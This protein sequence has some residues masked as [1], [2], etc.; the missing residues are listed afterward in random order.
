M[1]CQSSRFCGKARPWGLTRHRATIRHIL[2]PYHLPRT[3]TRYQ[4]TRGNH[5]GQP[6]WRYPKLF[7][8]QASDH[9]ELS[10]TPH[11]LAA[12]QEMRRRASERNHLAAA[13]RQ[14]LATCHFL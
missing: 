10:R 3:R 1:E 13:V 12:P 5:P 11:M 14:S 7:T 9:L 6:L 8:F 2:A 4:R